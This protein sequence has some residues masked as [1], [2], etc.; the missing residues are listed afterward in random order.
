MTGPQQRRGY[1]QLEEA[2]TMEN[3]FDLDC[4][5]NLNRYL[6]ENVVTPKEKA[7]HYYFVT[8]LNIALCVC[9][10]ACCALPCLYLAYKESKNVRQD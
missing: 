2:N 4:L 6:I 5:N 10:C 8:V 1:V 9:L 7:K 3:D